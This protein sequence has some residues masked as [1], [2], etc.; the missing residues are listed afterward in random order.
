MNAPS[1]S[2]A[3]SNSASSHSTAPAPQT[4]LSPSAPP[5]EQEVQEVQDRYAKRLKAR[6]AQPKI[7]VV[8]ARDGILDCFVAT[9][10][11]GLKQGIAG[12]LGI[13]AREEQVAHIAQAL[14]RKKLRARGAS[15]EAPTID[16][17][18]AVKSE[19]DAEWHFHELPAELSGIHD[20]VC[21][22]MLSKAEGSLDHAGARSAVRPSG[23]AAA[24]VP[25]TTSAPRSSTN[26]NLRA[27]LA[28][29][30]E[31]TSAIV[32][33][34]ESVSALRDRL[35]KVRQLLETIGAFEG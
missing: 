3:S 30:L 25:S 21:S 33:E 23:S 18:E 20:Q 9:Y 28:D 27:A 32:R 19:V 8:S 11:G 34:G 22:L 15:F 16:T 10:F 17:L 6:L 7:D 14:F 2:T 26:L 29:Y 24:P 12:H 13:D 35:A 31:E 5:R 4:A 1:P